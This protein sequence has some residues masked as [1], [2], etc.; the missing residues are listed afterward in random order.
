MMLDALHE[1][2]KLSGGQAARLDLEL[3]VRLVR[4][5]RGST[6][7]WRWML[8]CEPKIRGAASVAVGESVIL[9]RAHLHRMYSKIHAIIA[10]I[11]HVQMNISP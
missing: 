6:S 1:A 4:P 8:G 7:A 3:A 9:L 10:V 2:T 11:E 5:F